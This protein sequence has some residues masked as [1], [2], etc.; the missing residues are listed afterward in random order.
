MSTFF[1]FLPNT[2]KNRRREWPVNRGCSL[3]HS[4]F[5]FWLFILNTVRYHSFSFHVSWIHLNIYTPMVPCYFFFWVSYVCS[6]SW[7]GDSLV[8][9]MLLICFDFFPTKSIYGYKHLNFFSLNIILLFKCIFKLR[10][11]FIISNS[12]CLPTMKQTYL[13]IL[14]WQL[15]CVVF[16][17]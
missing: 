10:Q 16:I 15:F 7:I 17:D 13:L 2:T 5:F 8:F 6:I 11:I 12:F 14:Y 1:P 4:L 9:N 3:F